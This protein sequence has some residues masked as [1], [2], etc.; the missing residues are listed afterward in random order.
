MH[1]PVS[2]SRGVRNRTLY[3]RMADL[4]A[5]QAR[6]LVRSNMVNYRDSRHAQVSMLLPASG[7]V[8]LWSSGAV[9]SEIGVQHGSP[10]AL[11]IFRYVV[12]LVVMAGISAS[13]GRLLPRKGTRLRVALVGLCISGLYSTS[14]LLAL[15]N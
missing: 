9:V 4:T 13:R 10:F 11:L 12:A 2:Q 15:A 1:R 7:F 14:Y 6:E 8:L 3:K 5:R